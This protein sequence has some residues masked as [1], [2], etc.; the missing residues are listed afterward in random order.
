MLQPPVEIP[1]PAKGPRKRFLDP[2]V[3]PQPAF[4][5]TAVLQ[6]PEAVQSAS[7]PTAVLK[8][9]PEVR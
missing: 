8:Q 6:T 7:L 9:A 1:F 3:N 4:Q 2:E 5:P